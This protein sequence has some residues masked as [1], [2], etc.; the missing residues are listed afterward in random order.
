M[1]PG[2]VAVD[3]GTNDPDPA[4]DFEQV[5]YPN[6]NNWTSID[7]EEDLPLH[8]MSEEKARRRVVKG[9]GAP[10]GGEYEYNEKERYVD[11]YEDE[12]KDIYNKPRA[13]SARIGSGR[14]PQ[15]PL[16]P[17]TSLREFF[18]QNLEHLPPIIYTLLSCWTRFHKIGASNIVVWDEAHFGKFGSHYLK[19]E[20]YFDVHPPLGKMLVGL[21]GLLAG[22]DGS[23]EFKSGE[24][25]P[26]NVPYVAMRVMLATF[27]VGMVP[28]AWYTAVEL[29]M[30][31]W[32]CHLTAMMVLLDVGWLCISR[33]ILLDSMLLFFTVLTV[34][35]LTKFHNQQY[36]SFSID[37]WL[38]LFLT[39]ASIGAVTS[40]KMI[41]LFVT[42][43][44]GV[45]TV[46]DLW[47]KF[48]DTKMSW[49]DQAKHWGAR[50][51]CL[52]IVPIL[53]FMASF[54]IHFMVLNH[55]GPGDAQMS[56]LFQANLEGN[57]FAQNPLEIAFG[58]KITL[59]NMGWGGGL[60]HS[61]VQTYPVGSNQ[62]QVTCYHYKDSNNEW[63]VLP[64][65]DEPA[66]NPQGEIRYLKHGDVIILRH[67]PTTRNLHSHNIVA[68]V[69]KL[70]NEVS[71]YG[72]ET[73]GDSSDYWQVEVV[74]D[75][76]QGNHVDRIHSLTTRLRFKHKTL[77]CYL[78]AANAILPQ[79]GF[80]QVEVSCDKENNPKDIHT[81]WNVESH[82]NERLPS[83]NTKFYKSPFLR[84]FWHLNVAMMT[85]NNAL[86]P[87]PDK[88]DILAS[89]PFD[90]P[91]I[92]LG[93]RMCGWGD[94]Q[95]KY[96]LMGT[97]VIW[98]GSTISLGVALVALL[99]YLL[100]W[101][102]KYKDMDA[103]EWDHFL[104][105]G[106]IAFFGWFF[107]FVPFLIMGR[108]TYLHHY[109]PTLYFAVL[110]FSHVLDHF[111]FSS[112][113]LTTK[114]KSIIFGVLSFTL[115]FTFWW[116]KGVAFGILG[117][118]NEHKGLQWR[119]SWNIYEN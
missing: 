91:F 67:V 55:S 116:F 46:E 21:A 68:P 93:L 89:K 3:F 42:A 88:E 77:G 62:Q 110:M 38:W 22:Y 118:I 14:L 79:W 83:G 27:G 49:R 20:F 34:F 35:C 45:Y 92:H 78:R 100:R 43:L 106:K 41:G 4:F 59:K 9:P 104:Y 32:A 58:S 8:Y 75:I 101:Q 112:R 114:T 39:G 105:V 47:E 95:L 108:V 113:N 19:R 65:W 82:W 61:H 51:F 81:Y 94:N 7:R 119:K 102:R 73:I 63:L 44:V 37:W 76:K 52:I 53:V 71:C 2:A 30:S 10:S 80:K 28:L 36:Q 56:S 64:R 48:G 70:N 90:W 5:P 18:M 111:I 84:D 72:N 96:Y 98:W 103:R 26:E 6:S 66:Y 16:P 12:S 50:I 99:I 25:Y 23:F 24:A 107:H 40:V 97:P 17:P 86:I 57:D 13:S 87:D 1:K 109:L 117:P 74:D 31:Q 60:L 54:K 33:F 69:S 11:Y 15:P 29:G 85:S 115:V